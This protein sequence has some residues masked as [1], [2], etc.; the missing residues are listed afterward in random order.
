MHITAIELTAD[1]LPR[2]HALWADR[3]AYGDREFAL[4]MNSARRL[5]MEECA[6]GSIVLDDDR[7]RAYCLTAAVTESFADRYLRDPYPHLGKDL[8]LLR[9]AGN[10]RAILTR[11]E[12]AE[13]NAGAGLQLAVLSSNVDDA[14]P[15]RE[16]VLGVAMQAFGEIHRGYRT[17]RIINEAFGEHAIQALVASG[18]YDVRHMF[19]PPPGAT[20]RSVVGVLTREDARARP[21]PMLPLFVYSPP[22]VRFTP[23]E[24][25]LLRAALLGGTD[26]ALSARLGIALSSVK[27]RWTRILQRAGSRV[28][29]LFDEVPMPQRANRRGTQIRHLIL[30]YVRA[31]PS[32]LTP[33]ATSANGCPPRAS[34]HQHALTAAGER[35]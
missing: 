25:R 32:E 14:S 4:A 13:R 15:D 8:L 18:C 7:P 33:F 30:A 2:C 16:S 20:A 28:P 29:G 23:G 27:A 6:V 1:N 5:L 3:G 21:H 11:R 9:S 24:Q 10:R 34:C 31:N 22:R 12:I 17:A 19:A 26:D 35:G